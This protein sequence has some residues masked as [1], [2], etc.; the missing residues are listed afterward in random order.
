MLLYVSLNYYFWPLPRTNL[1]RKHISQRSIIITSIPYTTYVGGLMGKE[2]K[3][4]LDTFI[5]ILIP[6]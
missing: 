1:F 4:Q 3:L 5:F 2:K 6:K